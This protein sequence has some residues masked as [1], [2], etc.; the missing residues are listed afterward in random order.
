[1]TYSAVLSGMFNPAFDPVDGRRGRHT[2][3]LAPTFDPLSLGNDL[4]LWWDTGLLATG[5]ITDWPAR[6]GGVTLEPGGTG[7]ISF[8]GTMVGI[9]TTAFLFAANSWNHG[10]PYEIWQI[11]DQTQAAGSADSYSFM[12]GS[13]PTSVGLAYTPPIGGQSSAYIGA[14]SL[15]GGDNYHGVHVIRW[16]FQSGRMLGYLD[17]KPGV[18]AVGDVPNFGLPSSL[19]IGADNQGAK[20]WH[21]RIGD[22]IVTKPLSSGEAEAMWRF[23][24]GKA[25]L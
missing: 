12:V 17:R 5:A 22:T 6:K 18:P 24:M 14:T 7:T 19:F 16:S 25:G 9:T 13:G 15:F 20:L 11:V 23:T 3:P 8:D 10:E 1:M 4:L 2:S 21:G